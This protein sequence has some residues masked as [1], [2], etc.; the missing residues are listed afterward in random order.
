M[1]A[2]QRRKGAAFERVVST[3]F[4]TIFAGAKRGLGQARSG[5]EVSDVAGIP[6]FW[7]E[8]KHHRRTNA[9]AALAQAIEAS[10]GKGLVPIAICK[11]NG[12]D[13]TVTIRL[14][15]FLD[16][17]RKVYGCSSPS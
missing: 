6:D 2:M 16:L 3:L 15:D 10:T 4:R 12:E 7:P 1:G 14:S 17:L 5:G 9:R 13:P 8:C 11:D